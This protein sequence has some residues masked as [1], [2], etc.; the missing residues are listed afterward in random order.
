MGR[1]TGFWEGW[2]RRAAVFPRLSFGAHRE[3]AWGAGQT[4]GSSPVVPITSYWCD[5]EMG[6]FVSGRGGRGISGSPFLLLLK[7]V[8]SS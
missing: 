3:P 4:A 1:G 5:G 8:W 6:A 7:T 2:A